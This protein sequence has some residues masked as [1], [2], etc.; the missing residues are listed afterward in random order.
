MGCDVAPPLRTAN[1]QGQEV[2]QR[3]EKERA[4]RGYVSV[5]FGLPMKPPITGEEEEDILAKQHG[6]IGVLVLST[7]FRLL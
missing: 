3:G 6:S 2:N 4:S 5:L 7:E 1:L